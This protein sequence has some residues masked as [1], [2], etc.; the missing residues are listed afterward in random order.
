MAHLEALVASATSPGQ[1][2]RA[3]LI[4]RV[5]FLFDAAQELSQTYDQ[6]MAAL[7]PVYMPRREHYLRAEAQVVAD[8]VAAGVQSGEFS[9]DDPDEIALSLLLATNSLMP[10]SLGRE[11][12]ADR[13]TVERRV[14]RIA[15]LLL[16]GGLQRRG[17]GG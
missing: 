4:G 6:M 14:T 10:F 7:R 9:V 8:V 16:N 12:R 1:A 5:L 3:L 13:A 15:D 2:L 11:Q 17:E